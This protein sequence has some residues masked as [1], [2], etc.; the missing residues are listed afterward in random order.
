V[1]AAGCDTVVAA[2]SVAAEVIDATGA[3]DAFCGGFLAGFAQ[4]NDVAEAALRATVSA[5][6]ALA[7]VGPTALAAVSA[8][9]ASARLADARRRMTRVPFRV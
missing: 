4:F 8:D 9:A 6:F 1:H 7:S 2:P 5:S 3:G